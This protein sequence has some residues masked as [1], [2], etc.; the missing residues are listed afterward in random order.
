MIGCGIDS[1][2]DPPAPPHPASAMVA[3]PTAVAKFVR[4]FVSP[5][6]N[7]S[8]RSVAA[9]GDPRAKGL[10]KLAVAVNEFA[11]LIE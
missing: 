8:A 11:L 9:L 6:M 4:I 2:P 3:R 1:M 7:L 5:L 10:M